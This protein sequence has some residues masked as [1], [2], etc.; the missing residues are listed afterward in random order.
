MMPLPPPVAELVAR[1][2]PLDEHAM[3][4]ARRRHAELTKPQG[5]LGR[6][7]D[8]AIHLAG[9]QGT[10]RSR[11]NRPAVV[12][13]AADHGVAREGVSAYPAQVTA[14]MLANF[15][16]GGAAINAIA[17]Q[18]GA[19]VV[20]VDFG[21]ASPGGPPPG[22]ID[23]RIAPGTASFLHRSAMLPEQATAAIL[24]GA[25]VFEAEFA[26]KADLLATGEMGI[27]NTTSSAAITAVLTGKP[28]DSVTGRGTGIDDTRLEQKVRVIEQALQYHQPDPDDPLA[29][30]VALG[31]FEIAGLVGVMLAAATNRV[32]VL[33]DG[34]ICS[35]AA[36]V[37]V[38]IAPLLRDYLIASHLSVECGHV[39]VLEALQ[40]EPLFDL[41]LRLGEGT[42][43]ALAIPVVRSAAAILDE[44]ATFREAG[45]SQE[46]AE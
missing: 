5:S 26:G 40:L 9:I 31:G 19:R 42:G 32:P 23:R 8:L 3:R 33:L 39:A 35:T 46:T 45:V 11:C 2:E 15:V 36:L 21:V 30:L 1:I 20:V 24:A 10:A 44:M 29:V 37:A 28:V 18:V 34:Y 12:V 38:R 13:A 14:Q 16:C 27:G 17:R 22:V 43:A 6:L 4:A 25:E 41:S 7:E